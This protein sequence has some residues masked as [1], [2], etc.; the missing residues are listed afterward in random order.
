M[1]LRIV[2]RNGNDYMI[3]S[4]TIFSTDASYFKIV[5]K[6]QN[7]ALANII[8]GVINSNWKLVK[9]MVDPTLNKCFSNIIQELVLQPIFDKICYQDIVNFFFK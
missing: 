2:Q 1:K 4:D 7:V 9:S 3:I 5:Y 6:C 8:G